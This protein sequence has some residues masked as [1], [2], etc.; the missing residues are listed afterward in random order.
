MKEIS[1]FVLGA[2]TAALLAAG[3]VQAQAPNIENLKQMK[4]SG[5]DPSMPP[6]PQEGKNAATISPRRGRQ[7]KKLETQT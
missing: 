4:V 6:V 7:P 2:V 3:P 5:V 1:T